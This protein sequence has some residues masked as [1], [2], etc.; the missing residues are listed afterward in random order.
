MAVTVEQLL[1]S[2]ANLMGPL[3]QHVQAQQ[4]GMA[5]LVQKFSDRG[6]GRNKEGASDKGAVEEASR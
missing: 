3:M 4:Q 5:Q 2:L 1:Q 6:V